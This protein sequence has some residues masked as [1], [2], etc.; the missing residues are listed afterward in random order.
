MI[1]FYRTITFLMI[2]ISVGCAKD[3][4]DLVEKPKIFEI[5]SDN[6]IGSYR[7]SGIYLESEIS[8]SDKSIEKE[9]FLDSLVPVCRKDDV[10]I[11]SSLAK[12]ILYSNGFACQGDTESNYVEAGNW[13]LDGVNLNVDYYPEFEGKLNISYL[14]EIDS[15]VIVSLTEK[16]LILKRYPPITIDSEVV[17]Y[18]EEYYDIWYG[19]E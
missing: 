8:F 3:D 7:L 1:N 9:N 12:K 15:T 19:I 10:A 17:Y 5:T 13:N 14:S 6:L 18:Y 4:E 16:K 2:S 11:F